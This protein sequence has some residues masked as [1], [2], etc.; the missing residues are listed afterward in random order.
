MVQFR[1][2]SVGLSFGYAVGRE[3]TVLTFQYTND[4]PYYAS[5][6]DSAS[7]DA[8]FCYAKQYSEY[9]GENMISHADA[10]LALREFFD[11]YE[12]PSVIK[13]EKL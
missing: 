5:L 3:K 12:L 4:P 10:A 2:D 6:T 9:P 11:T 8:W 7:E 13:W 1:D